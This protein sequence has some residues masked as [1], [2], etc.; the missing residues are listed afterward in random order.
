MIRLVTCDIDGTLLHGEETEVAPA[1]LRQI[2]RLREK[3]ILFCPASGRQYASLRRLFAPV[4]N[5]IAYI[6][7]NGAVVFGPG[8]PGPVWGKVPMDRQAALRLCR[9]LH[10]QAAILKERSPSCGCGTIYDGTFSGTL[11]AGDGVTAE[12]LL[13]N[14]IAV[15]GESQVET[16]L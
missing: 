6:C 11:T 2:V 16:L 1:A 5:E 9:L 4:Q 7:E 3:G 13:Q 8:N 12:L 15:L 14:G 10:C